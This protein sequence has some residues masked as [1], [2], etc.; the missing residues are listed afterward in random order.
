MSHLSLLLCQNKKTKTTS[1]VKTKHK[2][3]LINTFPTSLTCHSNTLFYSQ[4]CTKAPFFKFTRT[5]T[6]LAESTTNTASILH[7]T[8]N[9]FTHLLLPPH[10]L[11]PNIYSLPKATRVNICDLISPRT[12]FSYKPSINPIE[13][14]TVS[15]LPLLITFQYILN[16]SINQH[17]E[18]I[19]EKESLI[20]IKWYVQREVDTVLVILSKRERD[21]WMWIIE[22]GVGVGNCWGWIG[23]LNEWTPSALFTVGIIENGLLCVGKERGSLLKRIGFEV[24]LERGDL[25]FICQKR[26]LLEGGG[27][28]SE[29]R[30][31]CVGVWL[32]VVMGF[33]YNWLCV[34]EWVWWWWFGLVVG[35]IDLAWLLLVA[36]AN[37]CIGTWIGPSSSTSGVIEVTFTIWGVCNGP[38]CW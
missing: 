27:K 9:T 15:K 2:T 13:S 8:R 3:K 20:I 31:V 1:S 34:S 21:E 28:L 35:R 5:V 24:F 19:V 16:I 38:I 37:L 32:V 7:S 36:V 11:S 29:V 22:K 4:A 23:F 18:E 33:V 25:F 10:P 6:P 17:A 14:H 30:R 12:I 26:G